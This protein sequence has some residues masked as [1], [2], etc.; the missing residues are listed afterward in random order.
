[1]QKKNQIQITNLSKE[2]LKGL[3]W[4]EEKTRENEIC[5]IEADKGGAILIVYPELLR[6]KTLE[7]LKELKDL[8]CLVVIYLMCSGFKNYSDR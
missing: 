1:M 6:K 5:V 4:L 8:S 2:E 3:K 7:K